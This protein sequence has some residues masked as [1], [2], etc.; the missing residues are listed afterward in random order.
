M[1][2]FFFVLLFILLIR[3]Q[4]GDCHSTAI[5]N[6]REH[7]S[8]GADFVGILLLCQSGLVFFTDYA[9]MISRYLFLFFLSYF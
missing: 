7:L 9:S 1:S 6:L 5:R 2:T 3:W 4:Y 8:S